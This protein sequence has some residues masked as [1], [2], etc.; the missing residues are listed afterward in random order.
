MK[1]AIQYNHTSGEFASSYREARRAVR[2]EAKIRCMLG[3][4]I[5]LR[6]VECDGEEYVY[7]STA[8]LRRDGDGSRAFAVISENS[9]A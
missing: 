7:L 2:R 5:R 3:M 4:T 8:D 1:Y 9:N 6:S